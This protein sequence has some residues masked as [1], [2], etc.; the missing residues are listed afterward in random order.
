MT[1]AAEYD[2]QFAA[3]RDELRRAAIALLDEAR[4]KAEAEAKKLHLSDV[5]LADARVGEAFTAT[6]AARGGTPPY[7]YAAAEG[8]KLPPGL[9]LASDGKISGTPTA[10]GMHQLKITVQDSAQGAANAKSTA[11]GTVTLGVLPQ[12]AITTEHLS[13][14]ELAAMV[15]R[16]SLIGVAPPRA[17]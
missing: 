14:A 13:E 4:V 1:R 16:D 7:R 8:T 11:N 17:E 10:A 15:T 3:A 9:E 6:I 2:P 5:R 12:P